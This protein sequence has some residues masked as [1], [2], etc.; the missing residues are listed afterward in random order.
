MKEIEEPKYTVHFQGSADTAHRSSYY[1]NFPK[2]DDVAKKVINNFRK[3][4]YVSCVLVYPRPHHLPSADAFFTK[5]EIQPNS[6]K[7]SMVDPK[8][9][10]PWFQIQMSNLR[11]MG[12]V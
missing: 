3:I 9:T 8:T 5:S 6:P 11:E 12:F 1:P 4:M 2:R 10:K 7:S